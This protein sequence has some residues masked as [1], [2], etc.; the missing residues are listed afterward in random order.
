V[1]ALNDNFQEVVLQATGADALYHIEDI[2]SLWSGYGKIM[3]YGL[4]GADRDRVVVKHVKLPDQHHHPRG[5]NTD[6]S[7]Q[8]KIRSY[9][10]ETAW[11]RDWAPACDARCRVP[12]CLALEA[13]ADEFLMVFEDLDA[14]G[15]PLRKNA[16][17]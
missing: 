17:D 6:R 16:R 15:F 11:Y 5:W 8:R 13:D 12:A 3:R 9:Q 2:Q 4:R 10:V 14:S 7:H 1:P